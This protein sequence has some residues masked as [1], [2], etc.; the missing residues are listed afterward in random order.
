[1]APSNICN[2]SLV[3]PSNICNRSL[4]A[5]SNICNR[6]LV[7]PSN[8]C[9]R[10][11]VATVPSMIET[12]VPS[13]GIQEY[14]R[15]VSVYSYSHSCFFALYLLQCKYKTSKYSTNGLESCKN[16]LLHGIHL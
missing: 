13:R 15:I 11:L 7:A 8:I 16:S 5:P 14:I 10:S 12:L 9:N 3:A 2:R 4:V 1:M 6:S